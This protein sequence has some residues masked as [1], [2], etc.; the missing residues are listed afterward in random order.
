MSSFRA[1]AQTV[2]V[3][4]PILHKGKPDAHALFALSNS[5]RFLHTKVTV[6]YIIYVYD[7]E[8]VNTLSF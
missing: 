6:L 1:I 8:T 2:R 7:E 5:V 3:R 4:L